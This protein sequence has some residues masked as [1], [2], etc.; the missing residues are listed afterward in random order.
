MVNTVGIVII[1]A[2]QSVA[3]AFTIGLVGYVSVKFPKDNP[4]LPQKLVG[5][6]SRFTFH[7]LL[8]SLI[9]GTIARAIT[10]DSI[11]LYW[12]VVV[13]AFFVLGISYV[14]ATIMQCFIPIKNVYDF[15]ALRVSVT[16]PN[17]VAL[18]ILIFPSLCEFP[19]VHN[20][21]M[22]AQFGDDGLSPEELEEKCVEQASTLIFCYFFGF[23]FLFWGVGY[24]QLMG[25]A[26]DKALEASNESTETEVSLQQE[27]PSQEDYSQQSPSPI[28]ID[29]GETDQQKKEG[30]SAI[31]AVDMTGAIESIKSPSAIGNTRA[32]ED[33]NAG[34]IRFGVFSNTINACKKTLTSAG[35]IASILGFLTACIPPLQRA[36]FEAEAPLRF[37][38]SA[39]EALGTASSSMSTIIVAASLVPPAKEESDSTREVDTNHENGNPGDLAAPTNAQG[40]RRARMTSLGH[41]ISSG[42]VRMVKAMTRSTPEMRR[43]SLW[44]CLSR[45]VVT[46]AFVVGIILAMDC[47]FHV[48]DPVPN[49]AI[50]VIIINSCL[51]GASI[52]VVLL[53][54]KM[55]L[56]ET[57]TVVAKVY[58]VCYIV[59]IFTIAAWTAV[60]LYIT[61]PDEDGNTYCSRQ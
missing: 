27:A 33:E 26:K 2:A 53:K 18:P 10:L 41:S 35:F 58:L 8:L 43:L 42:S 3:K 36:L 12:Y 49:L 29:E 51:P 52:V 40:G 17:I 56:E 34:E 24:P 57:A 7:T 9:Y 55:V 20:G 46:P 28:A 19:V 39:I 14:V 50:L 21:Y 16:F 5:T 22:R 4:F 59:C 13:G 54:S 61:L 30:N 6:F 15:R 1:A 11:G 47:G 37:L 38:G 23:M 44:F 60:G 32:T 31:A 48:L 45:L 25:A